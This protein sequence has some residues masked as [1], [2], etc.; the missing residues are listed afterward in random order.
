MRVRGISRPAWHLKRCLTTQAG[1]IS[2]DR[3]I[4]RPGVQVAAK[5]GK[6]RRFFCPR[7]KAYRL[8]IMAKLR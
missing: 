8:S 4:T 6:M 2:Q 3:E 1:E 5:S 7:P